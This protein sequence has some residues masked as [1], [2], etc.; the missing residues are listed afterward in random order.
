MEPC[1]DPCE[2]GTACGQEGHDEQPMTAGN[3]AWPIESYPEESHGPPCEGEGPCDQD[4]Y[5]EQQYVAGDKSYPPG[6]YPEDQVD[7][8]GPPCQGEGPC[9]DSYA[10]HEEE[11]ASGKVWELESVSTDVQE[12]G[13][14]PK[15]P[16]GPE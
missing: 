4:G 1:S 9:Q 16:C 7:Q 11:R 14:C 13:P 2:Y 8:D 15:G 5:G 3:G 6:S 10:K 12:K